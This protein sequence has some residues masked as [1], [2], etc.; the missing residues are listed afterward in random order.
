MKSL[1]FGNATYKHKIVYCFIDLPNFFLGFGSCL[2]TYT[3]SDSAILHT[4]GTVS[5]PNLI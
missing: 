4:P 2:D 1:P 3:Y 5:L